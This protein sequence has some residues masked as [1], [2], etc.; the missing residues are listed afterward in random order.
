M[1][2]HLMMLV[3]LL[4]AL[5]IAIPAFAA[6]E[7]KYGGQYRTR[8]ISQDNFDGTD[9]AA[10][11]KNFIDQRLRMYF[12]FVASENLRVVTKFEIGDSTWGQDT[13]RIG[14]GT[15]GGVGADAVNV[16]T[17]NAYVEFGIPTTPVKALVG[18][19]GIAL[20]NSWI[21]DDDFSAAV[22][23]ANFDPLM[24]SLGYIA[25]QN[26]DVTSENENIDSVYLSLD[27]AGAQVGPGVL[28]GSLV[29][30]YQYGHNTAVSA[31]LGTL[32]TPVN[33]F[34]NDLLPDPFIDSNGLF[35]LGVNVA[36]KMDWMSAYVSFVKN[37]G[38]VD[39]INDDS[40]DYT[41]W[42]IDG[43]ASFF[44]G[45]WTVN[46]GGFY[47][48]GQDPTDDSS[49]IDFFTYPLSTSKYFSEIIGGGIFDRFSVGHTDEFGNIDNQWAGYGTPS[50]LWTATIG[51]AW[52]ALEKTKLSASYWYFGTAEDVVSGYTRGG[53]ELYDDTIGHEFDMYLTQ[54]IV[55]GL[56]LDLVGA[57][58]ITEDGYTAAAS[59][60]DVYEVGAR[61][62][63]NF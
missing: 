16:E 47:T 34:S 15:G 40:V 24:V 49:D 1:K 44:C 56:T 39:L 53:R 36:Y 12:Y 14:P 28:S 27:Y 32:A 5:T 37:L 59:K 57:Y 60:D 63:W 43:G 55:D 30:F 29:G 46:V 3:A 17:K 18:I 6:V 54:G 45:P 62:Q 42:M 50:N 26:N 9:D 11:N 4:V 35:D 48:S 51:A 8:W 13:S 10:D 2:K 38:S 23:K 58:L 52:Q 61:L 19:Q 25:A 7:F 33:Y 20:L 41:G 22:L 31:D 21:V